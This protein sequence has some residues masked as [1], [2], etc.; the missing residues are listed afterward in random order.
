ME[1]EA[2]HG[3]NVNVGWELCMSFATGA[4]QL[5]LAAP[6]ATLGD[7]VREPLPM[8]TEIQRSAPV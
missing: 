5:L 1:H 8:L 7:A 6:A 2:L 3:S 4:G